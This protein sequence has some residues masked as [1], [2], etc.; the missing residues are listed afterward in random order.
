MLGDNKKARATRSKPTPEYR[1]LTE[2][3]LLAWYTIVPAIYLV[4]C[5]AEH[6]FVQYFEPSYFGRHVN[7]GQLAVAVLWKK[8]EGANN[9]SHEPAKV[10]RREPTRIVTW[11]V[12]A[13]VRCRC[14]FSRLVSSCFRPS[15]VCTEFWVLLL[16]CSCFWSSHNQYSD[17]SATKVLYPCVSIPLTARPSRKSGRGIFDVR[18]HIVRAVNMKARQALT[19]LHKCWLRRTGFWRKKKQHVFFFIYW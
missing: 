1:K 14:R 9:E 12:R 6:C 2:G 5:L 19:N 10:C 13:G 17:Y 7:G 11:C 16:F 8:E 3:S 15:F 4:F 18:D